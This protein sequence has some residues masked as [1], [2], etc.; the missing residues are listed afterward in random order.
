LGHCLN[1]RHIWGDDGNACTGTDYCNDTPNQADENYGTP[2]FPTISCGNGPLGDMFMNFMDYSDDLALANFTPNQGERI[3]AL[4]EPGGPLFS[5]RSSLGCQAPTCDVPSGITTTPYAYTNAILEWIPTPIQEG[6]HI[7]YHQQGDTTWTDTTLMGAGINTFTLNNLQSGTYYEWQISSYC[8]T[9]TSSFSAVN[10]FFTAECSDTHEPNNM[11]SE[12]IGIGPNEGNDTINGMLDTH[13]D[14]D[15]FRFA[16]TNYKNVRIRLQSLP[17][18]YDIRV[19][20]SNGV[21]LIKSTLSGT[22]DEEIVLHNLKNGNYYI[23]VSGADSSIMDCYTMYLERNYSPVPVDKR[24]YNLETPGTG[25]ARLAAPPLGIFP[26]PASDEVNISV[27]TQTATSAHVSLL[28]ITG[29][30][31]L[32]RDFELIEGSNLMKL[33]LSGMV[34]GIYLVKVEQNGE[35]SYSRLVIR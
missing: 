7:L 28:N 23:R 1:L 26:N 34:G 30:V 12:A 2:P 9:D 15:W 27:L 31:M 3:L 32:E 25:H 11:M 33:D 4:F 8:A 16:M 17:G 24:N 20:R 19:Y 6:V 13:S 5:L 21:M 29:S 10:V 14:V 18:D 35:T 22:S